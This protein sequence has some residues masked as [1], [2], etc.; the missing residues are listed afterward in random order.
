MTRKEYFDTFYPGLKWI[1]LSESCKMIQYALWNAYDETGRI[2]NVLK[3]KFAYK[4]GVPLYNK[5]KD[6]E[7]Q[8]RKDVDELAGKH[9]SPM[10]SVETLEAISD[11][12]HDMA[13]ICD[14]YHKYFE[15]VDI[16]LLQEDNKNDETI[17]SDENPICSK[18]VEYKDEDPEHRKWFVKILDSKIPD[19]HNDSNKDQIIYDCLCLLYDELC[20]LGCL[21]HNNED[22]SIFIY[23]FSGFNGTYP[24]ERKLLWK[25]KDI[26]LGYIARCLLSDKRNVPMIFSTVASFFYNKN[27]K[28]M[29]LASATNYT[30]ED[31][32]EEKRKKLL[33]LSFIKAVELLK[34]CGFINVE[35]T[36]SRI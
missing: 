19:Q 16:S 28:T 4:N 29:N 21:N 23:R 12:I 26:L 3:F 15:V 36:S 11:P 22:K 35:F 24:T 30:V 2:V 6:Y 33:P 9:G 5:L 10:F 18:N 31:F 8:I 14:I 32:E 1:D 7:D 17:E 13:F 25:D 34:K 20:N 27:G